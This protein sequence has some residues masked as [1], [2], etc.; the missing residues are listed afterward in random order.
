MKPESS[1][2]CLQYPTTGRYP[3]P[4]ESSPHPHILSLAPVLSE[5]VLMWK[6]VKV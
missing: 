5:P 1:L 6:V 4:D 3:E 2:P